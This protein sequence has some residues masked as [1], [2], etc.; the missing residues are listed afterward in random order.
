MQS[1]P[2]TSSSGTQH[3]STCETRGKSQDA[4]M[5]IGV[6]GSR[7]HP[8]PVSCPSCCMLARMRYVH[9]SYE[10]MYVRRSR[11]V[12]LSARVPACLPRWPPVSGVGATTCGG[13][14]ELRDNII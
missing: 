1:V 13:T 5:P 9:S 10:Y 11:F 12:S 7:P 8:C 2:A 6:A 3:A 4:L 14:T